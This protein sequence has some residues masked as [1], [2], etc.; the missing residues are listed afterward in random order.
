MAFDLTNLR[1]LPGE[2]QVGEL[3]LGVG[4]RRV[5]TFSSAAL[6]VARCRGLHQ[7]ARPRRCAVSQP[8][9][10]V[11]ARARR[12]SSTRTL[13][14]GGER[15]RARRPSIAGATTTSTNCCADD[16]CA[17]S[18]VERA[19]EGDDAAE[20]G[21]RVGAVGALVGLAAAFA[22]ERR[23]RTGWRA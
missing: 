5:T 7:Q 18:R 11:R 12:A 13:R 22:A 20:G 17:P 9:R 21:G 2:Q 16:G 15:R 1:H 4:W 6:D 14:L 8:L 19:V 10:G 23:R 3:A